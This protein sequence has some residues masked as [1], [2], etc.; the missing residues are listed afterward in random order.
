MKL[1]DAEIS[2]LLF[3]EQASD[4]AT[5]AAGK[6]RLYLKAAGLYIVDDAGVVSGPSADLAAHLADATDAH[7]ASAVSYAGGT[8]MAATD[9]EAAIDE[10]ATEKANWAG[11]TFTGDIV[12]PD[13]VYDA[14]AWN[15]SLEAPTKNAVRDKIEALSGG[16][17]TY[18]RQGGSATV[19]ATAG[20]SN[21]TITGSPLIQVGA[22][23]FA[24]TGTQAITF[25]TAYTYAP[26]VLVSFGDPTLNGRSYVRADSISNTGFTISFDNPVA[27][28]ATV[29]WLAIGQ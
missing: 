21:Q 14:T 13:E 23:T 12:V 18:A 28:T 2:S 8:G 5:P 17:T 6:W 15:G 24:A 27:A 9:V 26:H 19:W 29:R 10:L 3:D 20:T 22:Y 4:P 16:G 7:D 1:T 11:G 25:P